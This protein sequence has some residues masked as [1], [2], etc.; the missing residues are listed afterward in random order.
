MSF[1]NIQ[2]AEGPFIIGAGPVRLAMWYPNG[3]DHGAQ[4]IMANPIGPGALEVSHFTKERRVRP[5]NGVEIVYSV[6]VTNVGEDTLFNIQG[7]GNV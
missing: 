1:N 3:E 2:P 4:W 5:Q 6:T 7:G